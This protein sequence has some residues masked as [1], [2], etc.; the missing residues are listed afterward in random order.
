MAKRHKKLKTPYVSSIHTLLYKNSKMKKQ[1]N[2][3]LLLLITGLL[4]SLSSCKLIGGIF[5]AGVWVGVLGVVA[6]VALI[7][8]LIRKK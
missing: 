7:L 2:I 1:L 4:F 5:K 3:S 6:V 8:F